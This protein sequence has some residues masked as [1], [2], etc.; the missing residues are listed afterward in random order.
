[1]STQAWPSPWPQQARQLSRPSLPPRG[2]QP[3]SPAPAQAAARSPSV[4]APAWPSTGTAVGTQARAERTSPPASPP[5]REQGPRAQQSLA[6]Q[7]QAQ[8]Q[9]AQQQ[10]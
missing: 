3:A 8:L 2:R 10:A 4:S 1:M 9:P 6:Q 7:P 5:E